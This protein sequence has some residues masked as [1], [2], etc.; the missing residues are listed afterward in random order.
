MRDAPTRT[1]V[2]AARAEDDQPGRWRGRLHQHREWRP[3]AEH[4]RRAGAADVH[5]DSCDCFLRA[6]PSRDQAVQVKEKASVCVESVSTML[7]RPASPTWPTTV[8][9]ITSVRGGP[10]IRT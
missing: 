5:V 2:I 3:A 6:L 10:D 9:Q 7:I 1:T 4:L 8:C